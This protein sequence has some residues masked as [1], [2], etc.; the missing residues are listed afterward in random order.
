MNSKKNRI[1]PNVSK[2]E[3][4]SFSVGYHNLPNWLLISLGLIIFIGIV[5]WIC[6]S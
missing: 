4:A 2:K 6:C 3:I 1:L 5:Y